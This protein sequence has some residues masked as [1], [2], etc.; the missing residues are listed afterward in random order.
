M[1]AEYLDTSIS[2]P[3]P[4]VYALLSATAFVVPTNPGPTVT[5]PTPTPA[6]A[7]IA[8]LTR[9]HTQNLCTWRTYTDTDKACKQKLLGLVP[10]V[11][12]CTLKKNYTAYAGITCLTLL[13]HLHS[14]YG[15]LTS[16]DIDD[17]YKRI[18]IPISGETEFETFVE[19]IKD[20]QEAVELHNPY[21]NTQIVTITENLIEST[22]FYT[23]D[24]R[25]WNRTETSR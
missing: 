1:D 9:E 23:M 7:V 19:Q 18:K 3:P 13:T 4:A 22:G 16:Q 5:I 6:S 8:S 14:E 17:I 2:Q 24:C 12:Y 21:T 10:E 11:Y 25:E 20:R 15:R